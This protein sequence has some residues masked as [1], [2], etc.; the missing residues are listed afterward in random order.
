MSRLA[1]IATLEVQADKRNEALRILLEHRK[2]CLRDEPGTVEFELLI[3]SE[4]SKLML[5]EVYADKDALDKHLKGP[6]FAQAKLLP[7]GMRTR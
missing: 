7:D 5:Y 3:P 1:I 2:R 4:P 6:S